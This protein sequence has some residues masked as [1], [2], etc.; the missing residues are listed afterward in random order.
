MKTTLKKILASE[1]WQSESINSLVESIPV[2]KERKLADDQLYLF[3]S[4]IWWQ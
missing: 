1:E 2:K 3:S 4:R